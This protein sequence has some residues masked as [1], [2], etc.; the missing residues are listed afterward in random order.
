MASDVE[1]AIRKAVED[2]TRAERINGVWH[3]HLPM[4][5]PDGS[6]VTV[7]ID[8]APGGVRVSDAGFAYG[9]A[10]RVD[11]SRSFRR[12]AN[13]IAEETGVCV[14]ERSIF[15]HAHLDSIES[16]VID[17]AETSWLVA[18]RVCK[19][20]WEGEDGELPPALR[21]RLARLFG[22]G[23]VE[24]SAKI[25]GSSTSEWDV[26]A[27]VRFDDHVAVF[28]AVRDHPNSIYK[29]STAIRDLSLLSAPPRLIAVVD[30][31]EAMGVRMNLLSPAKVLEAGNPDDIFLR[32]AA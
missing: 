16:A 8:Q 11:A 4:L 29:A 22:A 9:E 7:R 26:S 20:V 31:K 21:D 24:E 30:S 27:V 6:F 14:G 13:K 32:A 1:D 3:V 19:R 15:A 5:Y 18:D 2:L 10:D 12:T 25:R 23:R 17:V 28:Q